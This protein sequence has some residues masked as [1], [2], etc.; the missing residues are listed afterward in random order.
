M[1][2][3]RCR[4]AAAVDVEDDDVRLHRREVGKSL[5][6]RDGEQLQR[7]SGPGYAA[8]PSWSPDMKWLAFIRGVAIFRD[9]NA[10]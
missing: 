7:V 1:D 4:G 9:R 2:V 10:Y 6:S 3:G 8:V 5:A